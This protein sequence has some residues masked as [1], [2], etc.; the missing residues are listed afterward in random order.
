MSIVFE[1][2]SGYIGMLLAA[3]ALLGVQAY[4]DLS[5]PDYMA[6]IVNTGPYALD[7]GISPVIFREAFSSIDPPFN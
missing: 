2:M 3:M 5:L 7:M 4:C 1:Y 6:D